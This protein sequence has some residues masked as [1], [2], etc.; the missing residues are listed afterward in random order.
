MNINIVTLYNIVASIVL[1]GTAFFTTP[2][3]TRLLGTYQFGLYS[4]FNSWV[5]IITCVMGFAFHAAIGPGFYT[6]QNEYIDFRN[7]L[8]LSSIFIS[9][10][11]LGIV[12]FFTEYLSNTLEF[13]T[14]IIYI[15]GIMSMCRFIVNFVHTTYIYEK[16]AKEN[17][18]LSTSIAFISVVLSIVF[19]LF[20][21]ESE[22]YV[23]RIYGTTIIYVIASIISF[24]LL[25]SE[26]KIKTDIKYIKYG[27]TIGFPIIFHS[28]SQQILGQSD[29]IMMKSFGIS[30]DDVGIYSLFY[31]LS[32]VLS[33]ILNS[34]N[35]SWC[36]F[37]YDDVSEKRW[38]ILNKRCT[39]YLELFT[40]ICFGFLMMSREVSYL[41]AD[42]SYWGGIEIIPILTLAVYFTFLYQF[43]V[44][45]EFY[46]GKTKI[47]ALGTIFSG[48]LNIVLNFFLIPIYGMYGAAIATAIAYLLLFIVHFNIVNHLKEDSYHL[49]INFFYPGIIFLSCGVALFYIL[50]PWWCVRWSIGVIL[51]TIEL[52]RIFKRKT[53]F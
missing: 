44:N 20:S 27:F 2:I 3:F 7:T 53:I 8:L 13:N 21:S 49:K 17:F 31:T 10:F 30:L 14:K 43:P 19:I 47:I 42:S 4:L 41:M 16:K 48:I 28:L 46:H 37:Y 35:T 25:L 23:G 6:F 32:A 1:Q 9:F 11:E 12:F 50:K 34:L 45:F 39:S 52:V 38:D 15:L 5:L 18:I 29:R 36:P 22:K 51:G 33:T 24:A 40:I 26:K